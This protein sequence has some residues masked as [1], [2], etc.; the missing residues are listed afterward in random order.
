MFDIFSA[1]KM[2]ATPI[3]SVVSGWQQR[4]AV[5]LEG[6][7]A[8]SKAK[9]EANIDKIKTGQAADIAWEKTSIDQSGWKDE[10]FTIILSIP[11]VLC[12]VPQ[13]VG[14]IEDGFAVLE[15]TPE[16]YRYAIGIAISSAFGFR[17]FA[18]LMKLKKGD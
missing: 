17:Q 16:W 7:I 3:S 15:T 11:L 5:R 1:I 18:S 9:T 14:Y 10:F 13:C 12:F 8:I 6:D 4:K 2:V